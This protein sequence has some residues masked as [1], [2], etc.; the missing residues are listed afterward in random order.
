[1]M[2]WTYF[3]SRWPYFLVV[4]YSLFALVLWFAN[5]TDIMIPC[6]YTSISGYNCP[7]CGLTRAVILLLQ[8]E[9]K[10]AW[11]M[12]PLIFIVVPAISYF[13]IKDIISFKHGNKHL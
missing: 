2:F 7:G 10:A 1:M 9:L 4:I 13:V 5:G 3:K 6:I 12:N 8:F 11:Q